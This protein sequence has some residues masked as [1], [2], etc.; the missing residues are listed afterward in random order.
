V[1]RIEWSGDELQIYDRLEGR[2][3]H[4][5]ESR[6]L[7]APGS[8]PAEIALLGPGELRVE[9]AWASERFGERVATTA[10]TLFT[11][12]ELPQT[13]GFQVRCLD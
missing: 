2:G 5:V 13:I 10:A 8:P 3:R 11:D 12:L 4:R 9:E 7:W 6:L 1:R